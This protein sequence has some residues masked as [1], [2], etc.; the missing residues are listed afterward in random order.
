ME[1]DKIKTDEAL[2]VWE[3][4][5]R[6]A[7]TSGDPVRQEMKRIRNAQASKENNRTEFDAD[8]TFKDARAQEKAFSARLK[9]LEMQRLEGKLFSKEDI[10]ADARALAGEIRGRLLA[11]PA[12]YA[13]L[14]EGHSAREIERILGDAVNEVITEIRGAHIDG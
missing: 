11:L 10:E 5:L 12:R 3:A 6:K 7:K 1:G 8:K 9:Q 13:A 4:R 2:K 14:C